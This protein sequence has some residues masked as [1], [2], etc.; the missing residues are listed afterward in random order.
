MHII[1]NASGLE[2]SAKVVVPFVMQGLRAMLVA[3]LELFKHLSGRPVALVC[4]GEAIRVGRIGRCTFSQVHSQVH[5][6][7]CAA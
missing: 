1:C 7:T 2:R 3:Q 5:S 6:L 4:M